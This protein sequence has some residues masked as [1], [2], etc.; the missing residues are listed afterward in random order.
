MNPFKKIDKYSFT[1]LGFLQALGIFLYCSLVG[2]LLFT[3]NELFGPVRTFLGPL[4]LL[5]LLVASVLICA[6]LAFGYAVIL[7]W[8]HKDTKSA[9][10]LVSYTAG[11]LLLFVLIILVA[12]V[13]F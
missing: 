3:G 12:L 1:F 7:F 13:R 2:L 8:D 10:S 11:W 9:V 5:A 6:L 4:L